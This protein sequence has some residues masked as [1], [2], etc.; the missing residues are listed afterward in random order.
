MTAS[1]IMYGITGF[2]VSFVR[3]AGFGFLI[4]AVLCLFVRSD[5]FILRRHLTSLHGSFVP[6]LER[7]G[8]ALLCFLFV[9]AWS[10]VPKPS[11]NSVSND[12]SVSSV[13]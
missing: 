9:S 4:M 13:P 11:I 6:C 10:E 3:V 8:I 7:L 1:Y 2:I 5:S 12:A